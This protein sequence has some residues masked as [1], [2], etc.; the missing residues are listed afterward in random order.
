MGFD[1]KPR[2]KDAGWLH[3]GAF[4]WSWMLR[5]GVGLVIGYGPSKDPASF[6]YV[7]DKQGRC[8]GYSDGYYVSADLARAMAMAAFG[9]VSSCRRVIKQWDAL[10]PDDRKRDEEWNETYR[11]YTTPV[12]TD[13]IDAAEKFGVWAQKS[14]G[15]GIF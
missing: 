6:S 15:F 8:P 2:N 10:N 7:A 4:T 9:L 13:F 3:I 11:I 1:L 14:S 12:R 5:E